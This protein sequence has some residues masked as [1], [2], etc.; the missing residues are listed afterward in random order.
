MHE[1]GVSLLSLSG[2]QF[3]FGQ[4]WKRLSVQAVVC[5]PGGTDVSD[6][7][8]WRGGRV[9]VEGEG[10]EKRGGEEEEGGGRRE[11]GRVGWV[12]G[13]GGDALWDGDEKEGERGREGGREGWI[14]ESMRRANN[15]GSRAGGKEIYLNDRS[16][17]DRFGTKH[18]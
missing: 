17:H 5:D 4:G 8:G 9:V 11:G 14:E 13:E 2:E 12:G 10:R 6:G 1:A 3:F 18:K 15:G 16:Y 7:D